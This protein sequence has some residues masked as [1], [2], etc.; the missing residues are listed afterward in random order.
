MYGQPADTI[1]KLSAACRLCKLKCESIH[2]HEGL[3]LTWVCAG[4]WRGYASINPSG[5]T[6]ARPRTRRR[7]SLV[8]GVELELRAY[9]TIARSYLRRAVDWL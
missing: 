5:R 8:V 7:S 2:M 4:I 9:Q 1:Y 3:N 6:A